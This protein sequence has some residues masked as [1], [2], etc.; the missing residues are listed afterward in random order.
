MKRNIDEKQ[1]VLDMLMIKRTST[2]RTIDAEEVL[3]K[4]PPHETKK[5]TCPLN[6]EQRKIL[7]DAD[8]NIKERAKSEYHARCAKIKKI[9]L[10]T[11]GM[12]A[13]DLAT[14]VA[15]DDNTHS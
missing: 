5:I 7:Q 14:T 6:D 1:P 2:S 10:V 11:L 9:R 8:E 3:V 12:N 13:G 15:K 4:L